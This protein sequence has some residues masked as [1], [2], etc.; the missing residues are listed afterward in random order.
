VLPN[1]GAGPRALYA[2]LGGTLPVSS[3]AAA[4]GAPPMP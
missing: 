4:A 3:S 1:K 2:A